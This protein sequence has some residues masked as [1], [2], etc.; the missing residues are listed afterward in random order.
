M[1][2]GFGIP[3]EE[4]LH[5][6]YKMILVAVVIFALHKDSIAKKYGGSVKMK[7]SGGVMESVT[8]MPALKVMMKQN[9]ILKLLYI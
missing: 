2:F 1:T 4:N 9:N 3:P 5:S 6:A 8:V 7:Y